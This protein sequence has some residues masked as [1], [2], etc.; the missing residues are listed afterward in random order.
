MVGT[1]IFIKSYKYTYN[2]IPPIFGV[3]ID[4]MMM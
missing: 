3:V 1:F 2:K 4:V